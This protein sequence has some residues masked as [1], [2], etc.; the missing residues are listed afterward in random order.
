MKCFWDIDSVCKHPKVG[1]V[2][3]TDDRCRQCSYFSRAS[4]EVTGNAVNL[5]ELLKQ[6]KEHEARK[7][8]AKAAVRLAHSNLLEKAGSWLKAEV[9]QIVQGPVD[10][11]TYRLRLE[12][13]NACPRIERPEGA[14]LGFCGACG[15]G[16]NPRAELTVKARMP[17]AKCPLNAWDNPDAPRAPLP[18]TFGR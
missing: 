11:E 3:A 14:S 10:D 7:A 5:D 13:C 1:G 16:Q 15:C 8:E 4:R 12:V 2:E 18:D 6:R 9:S 17:A